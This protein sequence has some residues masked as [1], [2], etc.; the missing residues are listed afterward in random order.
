MSDNTLLTKANNIANRAP[1]RWES[2]LC[3]LPRIKI[4]GGGGP[5]IGNKNTIYSSFPEGNLGAL[6]KDWQE[7]I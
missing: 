4:R 6:S 7:D 3:P 5:S 2:I 1:V